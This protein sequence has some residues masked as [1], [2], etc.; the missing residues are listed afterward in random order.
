V[1]TLL[2]YIEFAHQIISSDVGINAQKGSNLCGSRL[3]VW[4]THL[5]SP[6]WFG[7]SLIRFQPHAGFALLASCLQVRMLARVGV[8]YQEGSPS[9]TTLS[10]QS[11]R[12]DH[13]NYS[14]LVHP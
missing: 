2:G 1:R 4:F 5:P 11:L 13:A 12:E 9:S 7:V 6:F 8:A 14:G 10:A 3:G